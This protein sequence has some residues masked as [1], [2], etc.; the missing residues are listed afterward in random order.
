MRHCLLSDKKEKGV[1][2]ENPKGKGQR[3]KKSFDLNYKNKD[4]ILWEQM[5]KMKRQGA[6]NITRIEKRNYQFIFSSVE[7]SPSKQTDRDKKKP[8]NLNSRDDSSLTKFWKKCCWVQLK[9]SIKV[10][11]ECFS[12]AKM[13][14]N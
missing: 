11:T 1:Y 9:A 4:S 7:N 8:K 14:I 10:P 5:K 3:D 2:E 6:R 12:F 13:V